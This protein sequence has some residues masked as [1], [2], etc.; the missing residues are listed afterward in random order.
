[1]IYE[2][3]RATGA[4]EAVQGLSELFNFLLENDNVQDFEVR[5]DQAIL[6]ASET[7]TEKVLEGLYQSKLQDFFQLQ[8]VLPLY[9]QETIRNN[10]QPS[11]QRLKASV[12]IQIDR[13]RRTRNFRVRSETVETGATTKSRKGKQAYVESGRMLSAKS[14]WTVFERRLMGFS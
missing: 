4:Y 5:W 6:S 13:T 11:Y 9:G 10:W 7:S 12:R 1:M 8:T 3:F 14:K 2:H